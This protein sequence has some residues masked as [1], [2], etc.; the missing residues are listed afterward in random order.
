MKR[1]IALLTVL[2]LC[3]IC[4]FAGEAAAGTLSCSVATTCAGGVVIWRMYATSNSHAEL[5]SRSNYANLVCCTG[6]TGLGNSCSGTFAT[7][8][9]L[10]STTNAHAEQNTQLNYANS[11]CISAPAG[12]S[13]TVGYQ[14]SSCTTP[15]AYD[16]TLGSM[17]TTTNSHVGDSNA[18]TIKICASASAAP[19]TLSFALSG[20]SIG[21][22]QLSSAIARF[23]TSDGTG[24]TTETE[25]H[26]FTVSTN[27]S[28]GYTVT[29]QGGTLASG[30]NAI[31]AIGGTNTASALG[32][33]QFGLRLVASGGTGSVTSPYALSGYAFAAT[34]TTT[35]VVAS[36]SQ[37]DGITTTYSARYV[38]NISANTQAGS[39]STTLTYA[40][41]ANF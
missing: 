10:S 13:V 8:L 12:G 23:A 7:A 17:S 16:T 22:G 35:S 33:K 11:A 5:P 41:T 38:A 15:V 20:N 25:A 14:S 29:V 26:N 4:S 34:A 6:V 24:T 32:T 19:Q 28:Q 39:Y 27:A 30:A 9:K 3:G 37:G 36:N 40:A 18:Y 1:I 31:T 2:S 21:F